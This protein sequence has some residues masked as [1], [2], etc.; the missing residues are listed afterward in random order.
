MWVRGAESK[1]VPCM[2]NSQCTAGAKRLRRL[3]YKLHAFGRQLVPQTKQHWELAHFT[4][5]RRSF[6]LVV[7]SS[8]ELARG[9]VFSIY[10]G[11]AIGVDARHMHVVMR[12]NSASEVCGVDGARVMKDAQ[13]SRFSDEVLV[14]HV[15]RCNEHGVCFVF[16]ISICNEKNEAVWP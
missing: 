4:C 11:D 16:V 8:V 12:C 2:T 15:K 1:K 9:L 6:S 5:G 7:V 10:V 3:V 14:R 13:L